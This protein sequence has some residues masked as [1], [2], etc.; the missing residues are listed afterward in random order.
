MNEKMYQVSKLVKEFKS[1]RRRIDN[2]QF[3][4]RALDLP[5]T[6]ADGAI[7]EA[8]EGKI[9]IE[10]LGA[11]TMEVAKLL[12][13]SQGANFQFSILIFERVYNGH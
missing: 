13:H 7:V 6:I 9:A 12:L 8:M 3:K 4:L 11:K 5:S 1:V 2:L 10:L